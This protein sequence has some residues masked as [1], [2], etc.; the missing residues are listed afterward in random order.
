MQHKSKNIKYTYFVSKIRDNSNMKRVRYTPM[1]ILLCVMHF[2]VDF[3]CASTLSICFT[4]VYKY[5]V[6]VSLASAAFLVYNCTAFL[7]QPLLGLW[8]DKIK[9]PL[10]LKLMMV[11]SAMSLIV[12]AIFEFAFATHA[13]GAILGAIFLGFGNAL[14]HVIGGK[15]SLEMSNNSTPGGLFVSTGA[16]GLSLGLM[17]SLD[18]LGGLIRLAIAMPFI[19]GILT[20]VH[21]FIPFENEK[22]VYKEI[23]APTKIMLVVLL[24]LCVAV[25]IRSFLGFFASSSPKL[26]GTWMVFLIA[27][28][29]FLGKAIGGII[30]DLAGPYVL[31]IMST[32]LATISGFL[33]EYVA[34]NYLFVLAIN[35]LMPLTLDCI[36]RIF[37]NKEGFAFGLLA[38]FLIPGYLIGQMLKGN[39]YDFSWVVVLLTGGMLFTIYIL[40]NNKK[41][42][43]K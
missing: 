14:F 23:K 35:L 22:I 30:Y 8:M 42:C 21:A 18:T 39:V 16:L 26:T 10:L 7:L 3:I 6:N 28:C 43:E 9:A 2:V 11:F 5:N 15:E 17:Y 24:L 1:L 19:F 31:I 25:A 41:I 4:S 29:A 37:P 32:V 40:I 33:L 34:F 36:R 13:F 38:A 20:A 12:G 27:V